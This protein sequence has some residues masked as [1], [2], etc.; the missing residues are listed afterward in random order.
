ML[1]PTM[2]TTSLRETFT[3]DASAEQVC[4]LESHL[5]LAKLKR[6]LFS[7]VSKHPLYQNGLKRRGH[8]PCP[9]YVVSKTTVRLPMAVAGRLLYEQMDNI[10]QK[11]LSTDE[12]VSSARHVV[13]A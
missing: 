4:R 8:S 5:S 11:R 13:F 7:S 9:R 6:M 1:D 10:R 2:A 3:G 12:N